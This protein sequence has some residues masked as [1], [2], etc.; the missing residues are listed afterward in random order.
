MKPPRNLRWPWCTLLLAFL[1]ACSDDTPQQQT[2]FAAYTIIQHAVID[3]TKGESEFAD[4]LTKY[5]GTTR[6]EG[7]DI[8]RYVEEMDTRDKVENDVE[9]RIRTSLPTF[10]TGDIAKSRKRFLVDVIS[11]YLQCTL[12]GNPLPPDLRRAIEERYAQYYG[13]ATDA[14]GLAATIASIENYRNGSVFS[15]DSLNL[16]NT[17]LRAYGNLLQISNRSEQ[18]CM[19]DVDDTLLPPTAW[20][21]GTL[22]VIE[23]QRRIPCFL[24]SEYGY[25]TMASDYVVVLKDKIRENARGQFDGLNGAPYTGESDRLFASLGLSMRSEDANRIVR[26]LLHRDFEGKS[27]EQV[28]RALTVE[29]AIHEAKHKTDEI[30][31]PTMTLNWDCEISAHLTQ[32]ICGNT[33]FH[34]LVDAIGRIEGFHEPQDDPE[35]ALLLSQLWGIAAKAAAPGYQEA[36]LRQDLRQV[37]DG[38]VTFS[39]RS[40]LPPLENFNRVVVPPIK[41]AAL[42]GKRGSF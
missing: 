29:T 10:G 32:A 8:I 30:D 9:I 36:R 22:S 35:I 18:A 12:H 6:S 5:F 17:Q 23:V 37:Y 1:W 41:A 20:K 39:S 7:K 25:S 2:A 34:S 4:T 3:L 40:H 26:A 21:S 11:P 15:V 42:R 31:L 24:P 14:N 27:A 28:A 38:Y 33:P 13:T 19:L 16:L